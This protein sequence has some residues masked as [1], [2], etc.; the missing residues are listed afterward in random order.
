MR[1]AYEGAP[2]TWPAAQI[3]ADVAYDE[4][5]ALP[6]PERGGDEADSAALVALGEALFHEPA[7]SRSGQISCASCHNPELAFTDRVRTAFGH[8]R[9]RGRRNTPTV[10]DK[11]GQP[12]FM[13]DG[14]AASL[15]AQA[16]GP[17]TNPVEMAA[18]PDRLVARLA[19][20]PA[21]RARFAT[22]F[23]AEAPT[24]AGAR[25]PVRF[26]RV[27]AALAAYQRSLH[28]PTAFDRFMAGEHDRLDDQQIFGLHLF[29]TKA[30]CANCHMGAR[31]TD[32]RFHNLGLHYYGRAY[33]DHGRYGVTGRPADMGAFRTPSLRHVGDTAPYMHNGLFPTLVGVVNLYNAGGAHPSPRADQAQDPLFPAT[34]D[35]LRPLDLS[36]QEVEALAAFLDAL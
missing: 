2:E 14:S 6:R 30:R 34:S 3:D 25:Q 10:L 9:Q 22:A 19:A 13:W 15:E 11:A 16:A 8:D 24:D 33:E 18:E 29:R 7:L 26:E 12:H 17:I 21:W 32:D 35:R 27:T 4:L 31:L 20:R 1:D 28:R 23:E 5:A 36:R